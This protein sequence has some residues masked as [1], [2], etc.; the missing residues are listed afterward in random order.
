MG[1]GITARSWRWAIV[2][3]LLTVV[4]LLLA[5][6]FGEEGAIR[7]T[8]DRGSV[9]AEERLQHAFEAQR[10]GFWI[11]ASGQVVRLL[12][13][14]LDGSRHQRII[15]A[16][17]TGQTLLIAHNIDLAPRVESLEPGGH[18]RFRG[19]YVWNDRGG[20]IHWTHHDPGGDSLGGWLEYRGRRYR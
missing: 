10:E 16:L 9:T 12:P 7:T 14:D 4:V 15:V 19:E 11:E 5:A 3:L 1:Q 13:D 18:L 8:V 20:V 6:R 17:D 2:G